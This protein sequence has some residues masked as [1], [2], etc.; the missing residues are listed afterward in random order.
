M[1]SRKVEIEGRFHSELI[2]ML[3]DISK[4][5]SGTTDKDTIS[6]RSA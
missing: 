3:V 1:E 2:G 4:P 6:W 5:G